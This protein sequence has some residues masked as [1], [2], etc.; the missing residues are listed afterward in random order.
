MELASAS[1]GHGGGKKSAKLR[2]MV[3]EVMAATVVETHDTV[4]S[5]DTRVTSAQSTDSVLN[6][7]GSL[8]KHLRSKKHL[9]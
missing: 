5:Y 4:V 7:G 6:H 9:R 3:V 1:P 2:K 8:I